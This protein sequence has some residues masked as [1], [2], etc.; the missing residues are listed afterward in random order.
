MRSPFLYQTVDGRG[1]GFMLTPILLFPYILC[2]F[3]L[4]G[5]YIKSW[6]IT[7]NFVNGRGS[8]GILMGPFQP[9]TQANITWSHHWKLCLASKDGQ[10]RLHGL[11]Y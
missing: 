3:N 1:E 6:R 11:H 4:Q 10:Y 2:V 8:L 9:T 7:Y 5:E